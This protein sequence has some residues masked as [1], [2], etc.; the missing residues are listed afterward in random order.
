MYEQPTCLLV[1]RADAKGDDVGVVVHGSVG[2]GHPPVEAA[3]WGWPHGAAADAQAMCV[4]GAQAGDDNRLAVGV[5][6][7]HQGLEPARHHLGMAGVQVSEQRH[8]ACM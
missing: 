2:E 7:P 1:A 5:D 8:Q 3:L 6:A 4:N